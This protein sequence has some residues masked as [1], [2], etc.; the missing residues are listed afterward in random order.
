MYFDFLRKELKKP[1]GRYVETAK[2]HHRFGRP[3]NE[4]NEFYKMIS[5]WEYDWCEGT[6]HYPV[7]AVGDTYTVALKLYKKWNKTA[8]RLYGEVKAVDGSLVDADKKEVVF[9]ID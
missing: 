6:E 5:K 1:E 7:E 2:I 8:N 4:A 3:S 9:G